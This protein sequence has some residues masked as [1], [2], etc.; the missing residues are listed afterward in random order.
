MGPT[1]SRDRNTTGHSENSRDLKVA[2]ALLLPLDGLEQRLEVAL[3]KAQRAMTLDHLEEH[4]GAVA[5]GPRE[6][7][8]E[9]AVLVAVDQDAPL[10]QLLD[11]SAHVADAL[12]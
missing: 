1:L 12:A 8:Q 4:G 5:D 6:D 7:L 3:A 10:L 2:P 11:R 9:V